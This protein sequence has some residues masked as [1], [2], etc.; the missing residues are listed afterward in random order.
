MSKRIVIFICI[1]ISPFLT[2]FI[3]NECFDTPHRT[4]KNVEEYC[5]WYCH[6]ITCTHWKSSYKKE[7]TQI[8]KMHKDIF[9]WYINSLHQNPLK[10]NYG[11][12][13]LLVFLV[14]YPIVG[15]LLVW[16]LIKRIK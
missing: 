5:T 7:P 3:V 4:H 9:D 16:N 10:L 12:I 6:D 15:S 11:I 14:G 2:M 13:N 1:L 8:K